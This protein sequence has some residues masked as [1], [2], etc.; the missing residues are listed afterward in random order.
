M[1]TYEELIAHKKTVAEIAKHAGADSLAYISIDGNVFCFV[2][3]CCICVTFCMLRVM[4]A[5]LSVYACL[6]LFIV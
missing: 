4:C 5:W 1:S 3:L 6:L 2:F